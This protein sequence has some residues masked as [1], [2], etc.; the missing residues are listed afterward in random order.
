MS[1]KGIYVSDSQTQK[2]LMEDLNKLLIKAS[3]D[4]GQLGRTVSHIS[5]KTSRI[6]FF[7]F[8]TVHVYGKLT[9]KCPWTLATRMSGADE[10]WNL[11][12]L[13]M[14]HRPLIFLRDHLQAIRKTDDNTALCS[15]R[16]QEYASSIK[17]EAQ[18]LSGQLE[19]LRFL[20]HTLLTAHQMQLLVLIKFSF[21]CRACHERRRAELKE[22]YTR[23][24]NWKESY[25]GSIEGPTFGVGRLV[26]SSQSSSSGISADIYATIPLPPSPLGRLTPTEVIEDQERG[27]R[28]RIHMEPDP[29]EVHI[30]KSRIFSGGAT[31]QPKQIE[32]ALSVKQ[33]FV[34]PQAKM[35]RDVAIQFR[36]HHGIQDNQKEGRME[37]ERDYKYAST[38]SRCRRVDCM[39][40][41]GIG[42]SPK[43][44]QV[45]FTS[46]T[47]TMDTETSQTSIG[48]GREEATPPRKEETYTTGPSKNPTATTNLGTRAAPTQDLVTQ[49]GH[50]HP[51]STFQVQQPV[52]KIGELVTTPPSVDSTEI[53][54]WLTLSRGQFATRGVPQYDIV[55][56]MNTAPRPIRTHDVEAQIFYEP[57]AT[58]FHDG[59][60][61]QNDR[62]NQVLTELSEGEFAGQ[63][64]PEKCVGSWSI[65]VVR[66]ATCGELM[67]SKPRI[68][69]VDMQISKPNAMQMS[70]SFNPRMCVAAECI[71]AQLN[72]HTNHASQ[73]STTTTAYC[74]LHSPATFHFTTPCYAACETR[75]IKDHRPHI[76]NVSCQVGTRLV[77]KEVKV[78][79]ISVKIGDKMVGGQLNLPVNT[80]LCPASVECQ[81][82]LT[83]DAGIQIADLKEARQLSLQ[84]SKGNLV[85]GVH[86]SS[87]SKRA[88]T[89]SRTQYS[90]PETCVLEINTSNV[91]T[92]LGSVMLS[93]RS[94]NQGTAGRKV[95]VEAGLE[96]TVDDMQLGNHASLYDP[97]YVG[98]GVPRQPIK[99][100]SCQVG[101]RLIPETLQVSAV[102]LQ[103]SHLQAANPSIDGVVYPT[104]VQMRT[105]LSEEAGITM[106]QTLETEH[107]N[108]QMSGRVYDAAVQ[109]SS[110]NFNEK[111]IGGPDNRKLCTLELNTPA[112]FT[113]GPFKRLSADSESA[114]AA[115]VVSLRNPMGNMMESQIVTCPTCQ[116]HFETSFKTPPTCR[117]AE[118]SSRRQTTLYTPS[119]TCSASTQVGTTLT[120]TNIQ[121]V[122]VKIKPRDVTTARHIAVG[123]DDLIC[124]S[125]VG[126]V[127]EL[128][129]TSGI[130]VLGL[131]EV[132]SM[133]VITEESV[134]QAD[135]HSQGEIVNR[136]QL[137]NIQVNLNQGRGGIVIGEVSKQP[138]QTNVSSTA[139]TM[140]QVG[141]E[142][143][144]KD[145][146]IG[147]VCHTC[148]GSGVADFSTPRN[149][150][151]MQHNT[152]DYSRKPSFIHQRTS[153]PFA[154][155]AE[156]QVGTRLRPAC[157][158]VA[159]IAIK[160]RSMAMA[161]QMGVDVESLMCP[162]KVQMEPELTELPG[163][164]IVDFKDVNNV[165]VQAGEIAV[166]AD[167]LMSRSLLS[168]AGVSKRPLQQMNIIGCD[169]SLTV[170]QFTRARNIQSATA[171][172]ESFTLCDIGCEIA[173]RNA[174][175]GTVCNQCRGSGKT[176][177]ME[178]PLAKG[179]AKNLF[180][181]SN[182]TESK[183]CQVGTVLTPT[184]LN[185]A[186]IEL[187]STQTNAAIT[188]RAIVYP[189]AVEMQ[190]KLTES[191]GIHLT[192][193]AS[194]ESVNMNLG[195]RQFMAAISQT[196]PTRSESS[197]LEVRS[198]HP[199]AVR[200]EMSTYRMAVGSIAS[201]G[202][203]QLKNA[204]CEFKIR[205]DGT[206]TSE[207]KHPLVAS[208][209]KRPPRRNL[210]RGE[211]K[212][213]HT[214]VG[215]LLV[216]NTIQVA[217]MSATVTDRRIASSLG[218]QSN[219]I[220]CPS[221]VDLET[222]LV[223]NSGITV[224]DV[225]DVK[226]VGIMVGD[227]RSVVSVT[228]RNAG[229][230][231]LSTAFEKPEPAYLTF[232]SRQPQN[233]YETRTMFHKP[234]V[235]APVNKPIDQ[236]GGCTFRVLQT[237]K[238]MR[239]ESF[240]ATPLIPVQSKS[241]RCEDIGCQVGITMVPGKMEVSPVKVNIADKTSAD[242]L[243]VPLG[244]AYHSSTLQYVA[245]ISE[246]AGVDIA[247]VNAV[248]RLELQVGSNVYP[249]TLDTSGL[250]N[251]AVGAAGSWNRR[252]ASANLPGPQKMSVTGTP[253]LPRA[254]ATIGPCLLA[255]KDCRST[256]ES[257]FEVVGLTLGGK[258]LQMKVNA[259]I[260]GKAL[261]L[262][263]EFTTGPSGTRFTGYLDS[264]RRLT[265]PAAVVDR[266]SLRRPDSRFCD[267]ACEALIKPNTMEKRLQTI[268][269]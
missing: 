216:P 244:S 55:T 204:G 5:S 125:T 183:T 159:K 63:K 242:I 67:T 31:L 238:T 123:F 46:I 43:A 122:G 228:G 141:C 52:S 162:V 95:L 74:A 61:P 115:L 201:T 39:T 168:V 188:G 139:V 213:A 255:Q 233:L 102:P 219:A 212:E 182:S 6:T 69:D 158:Q 81:P 209:E 113:D 126:L 155:T 215:T 13:N 58:G 214:Q 65:G 148:M 266:H 147:N 76:A 131:N 135:V 185:V 15:A 100:A 82:V 166:D 17:T 260:R 86:R 117:S 60:R 195:G 207:F 175:F 181:S 85:A 156:C 144:L 262:S 1:L 77:P 160:P 35:V 235:T 172:T 106:P 154:K 197:V 22:L 114:G 16:M 10:V 176:G 121:T 150:S 140:A 217:D 53:E 20:L 118:I 208:L 230:R 254:V 170:G 4:D 269:L 202:K 119:S 70:T 40:Q 180:Q 246:K 38:Q 157:L 51:N 103:I 257:S 222:R 84:T 196:H 134:Y 36:M 112:V 241:V 128:A 206:S 30:G 173:L 263:N 45:D 210:F 21:T 41:I 97:E 234:I 189:A 252:L 178:S 225:H 33:K 224:V 129:E 73:S 248:E 138:K 57:K 267:V 239:H 44:Q 133:N 152:I 142:F 232:T 11:K 250:K 71:C 247:N 205:D 169:G 223:E 249:A 59:R 163:I 24:H 127:A 231:T 186:G 190:S 23:V 25:N 37:R 87:S 227:K 104:K 243:G 101:A 98:T 99:H 259:D 136:S 240:A 199:E 62:S 34:P 2:R 120:P 130:R 149:M 94:R 151:F 42:K 146:K 107:V 68:T 245:Q 111:S 72:A 109:R 7:N 237:P 80:L 3:L 203:F 50:S 137:Q 164:E 96:F 265:S 32:A 191:S 29:Q 90:E 268:G 258:S 105:V 165:Q 9:A 66:D 198:F 54:T 64:P 253:A 93:R 47:A 124:P 89:T 26:L 200:G 143:T 236:N 218:L 226:E 48:S 192:E 92:G 161:K 88:K 153:T 184:A 193:V 19:S 91:E 256:K 261:L 110:R 116:R 27:R 179:S 18:C 8:A 28:I 211:A 171:A 14:L 187:V 229:V 167:I 12:E 132:S 75:R 251:K 83:E 145:T 56:Q 177:G 79:T 49:I 221:N 264:S 194:I 108:V 220:L 174:S 78:S